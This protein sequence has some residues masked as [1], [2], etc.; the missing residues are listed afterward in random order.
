[1][2]FEIDYVEPSLIRLKHAQPFL[3]HL[4]LIWLSLGTV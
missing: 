2:N 1:M 4:D 3:L